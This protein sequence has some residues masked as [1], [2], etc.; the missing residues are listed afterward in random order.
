MEW[1]RQSYVIGEG[2]SNDK[3]LPGA[4]YPP[5]TGVYPMNKTISG[6]ANDIGKGNWGV[7]QGQVRVESDLQWKEM[8]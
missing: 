4:R 2:N 6:T 8:I 7:S 1:T 3:Y 5:Q